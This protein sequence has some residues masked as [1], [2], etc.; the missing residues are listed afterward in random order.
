MFFSLTDNDSEDPAKP[1][2]DHPK[3]EVIFLDDDPETR[4]FTVSC[5]GAP[6]PNN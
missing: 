4:C 1:I 2:E 5:I 3:V 6:D